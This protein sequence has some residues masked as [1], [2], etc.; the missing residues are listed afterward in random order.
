MNR[1]RD[2]DWGECPECG[3][4]DCE[5]LT[6]AEPP[7]HCDGDIIRCKECG[8]LGQINCDSEMPATEYWNGRDGMEVR[9]EEDK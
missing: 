6:D 7:Y 8:E 9:L 3:S 2:Y 4:D 1:W 5:T